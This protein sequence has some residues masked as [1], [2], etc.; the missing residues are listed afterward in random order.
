[1]F[2]KKGTTADQ[3]IPTPRTRISKFYTRLGTAPTTS[4]IRSSDVIGSPHHQ[5]VYEID[6]LGSV[7]QLGL[8]NSISSDPR[9]INYWS[10]VD[11]LRRRREE[12][13][14]K[15]NVVLNAQ[16]R[17]VEDNHGNEE[18]QLLVEINQLEDMARE[19]MG[20][21]MYAKLRNDIA[22]PSTELSVAVLLGGLENPIQ[23]ESLLRAA[24]QQECRAVALRKK[25]DALRIRMIEYMNS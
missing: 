21:E 22:Q 4:M 12:H 15:M 2:L 18:A 10:E 9:D 24:K 25:N 13:N 17:R 5:G 7:K 23:P 8:H 11:A 20:K 14:K 16:N 6:S 19:D 3:V 1:M